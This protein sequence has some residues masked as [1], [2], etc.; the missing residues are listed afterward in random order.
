V[1]RN[2]HTGVYSGKEAFEKHLKGYFTSGKMNVYLKWVF[3]V[4][5]M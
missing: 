1:Y 4:E 2:V 3:Y 5:E